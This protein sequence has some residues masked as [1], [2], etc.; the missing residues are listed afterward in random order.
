MDAMMDYTNKFFDMPSQEKTRLEARNNPL[1]RGYNSMETGAHSCTPED[2]AENPPD[3]KES[4]TIGAEATATNGGDLDDA[5][6]ALLKKL[7]AL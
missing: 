7:R 3:L 6:D 2:A 4:F 5:A 1:W